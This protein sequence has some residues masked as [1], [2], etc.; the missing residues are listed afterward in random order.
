MKI[1]RTKPS[2]ASPAAEVHSDE[3]T[4]PL[5]GEVADAVPIASSALRSAALPTRLPNGCYLAA[6]T[7]E[8]L[9]LTTGLDLP[10][11]EDALAMLTVNAGAL[12]AQTLAGWPYETRVRL[13]LLNLDAGADD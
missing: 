3:G 6:V 4:V 1:R 9:T 13:F 10:R 2:C 7:D 8:Y 5:R 12:T 11:I